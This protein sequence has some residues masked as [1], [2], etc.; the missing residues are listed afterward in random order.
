[1]RERS[2]TLLNLILIPG[3]FVA[4]FLGARLFVDLEELPRT[5]E[6][7]MMVPHVQLADMGLE[8]P[9]GDAFTAEHSAGRW[10]LVYVAEADGSCDLSCRNALWYQMRQQQRAL[11]RDASRVRRIIVHTT[12]P[13]EELREFLDSRAEG[14]GELHADADALA[15]AFRKAE[16][17]PE[18]PHGRLYIMS[19]DGMVFLWYPVH[20]EREATLEEAQR[21]HDDLTHILRGA[22][23]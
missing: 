22:P 23:G 8:S 9:E 12:E 21:L 2:R 20:E 15:D 3:V 14:T 18:T 10:N 4:F 5:N 13:G 7:T 1:M 6:G 17:A 11:R 16:D 19:P